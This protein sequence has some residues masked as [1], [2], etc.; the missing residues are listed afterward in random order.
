M[1]TTVLTTTKEVGAAGFVVEDLSAATGATLVKVKAGAV[2]GVHLSNGTI[3]GA[4]RVLDMV[5]NAGSLDGAS[6]RRIHAKNLGRG[7]FRLRAARNVLVEDVVAL[8]GPTTDAYPTGFAT[9]DLPTTHL[10][11]RRVVARGFRGKPGK[12]YTN[13]DGWAQEE[14]STGTL[15]EDCTAS[16]NAD[17]GFDMKGQV[18]MARCL[19]EL[20]HRNLRLWG[21]FDV[22]DFT[23]IDPR[24][25]HIWLGGGARFKGGTIV[26]PTFIGGSGVPHI[27]I[28]SDTPAVT[29]TIV[30]PVVPTGETLRIEREGGAKAIVRVEFSTPGQRVA[31]AALPEPPRLAGAPVVVP[32]PAPAP[33]ISA[34]V[35][36]LQGKVD[37]LLAENAR[38][39]DR[40][41]AIAALAADAG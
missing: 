26:R 37:A 10:V 27:K 31:R 9:S 11:Y 7:F 13:G 15:L 14:Q 4:D 40:L 38:Y 17:A 30:D 3:D 35:T 36:V 8:A 6:F 5:D 25:A 2:T 20:N 24:N 18:V 12:T 16:D 33:D 19:G 1:T 22:T 41:R 21:S 28:D 39:R 29:V 34:V 32:A 23:S